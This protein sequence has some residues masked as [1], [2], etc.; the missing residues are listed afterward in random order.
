MVP[1]LASVAGATLDGTAAVMAIW[2]ARGAAGG[3]C[4]QTPWACPSSCAGATERP[5]GP[6]GGHFPVRDLQG[7]QGACV[8]GMRVT[9][10]RRGRL[11]SWYLAALS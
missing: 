1:A 8:A 4:W 6:A 2:P 7:L 3:A 9:L 11:W 5:S 10:P